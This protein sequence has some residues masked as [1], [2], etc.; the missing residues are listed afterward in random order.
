M[1]ICIV[2]LITLSVQ[3]VNIPK[4]DKPIDFAYAMYD[5]FDSM[6][7]NGDGFLTLQEAQNLIE[8]LSLDVF[9]SFDS[10]QDEQLT[11]EELQE[12]IKKLQTCGSQIRR[13]CSCAVTRVQTWV[14]DFIV[15]LFSMTILMFMGSSKN[16]SIK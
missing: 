8:G 12:A 6:D 5:N 7:A 1:G 11:K 4:V 3:N 16:T 9:L 2:L 14:S 13:G 15:I 10:N